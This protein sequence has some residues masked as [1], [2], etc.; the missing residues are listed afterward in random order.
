MTIPVQL[1]N[2]TIEVDLFHYI[3]RHTFWR[4]RDVLFFWGQIIAL[5]E[6]L[7][8]QG[9]E[10][11]ADSVKSQVA[12]LGFYIIETEFISEF[13]DYVGNLEVIVKLFEGKHQAISFDEFRS[14]L[15][16]YEP[17]LA[18]QPVLLDNDGRSQ[19][20][21]TLSWIEI[22]YRIGFIGFYLQPNCPLKAR[23]ETPWI[24]IHNEGDV[25]LKMIKTAHEDRILI[26]IHP[27][28]V[29]YLALNAYKE[30]LVCEMSDEYLI[31]Q[32]GRQMSHKV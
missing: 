3:L 28:F 18:F 17:Q 5:Y 26:T 6:H 4:P 8:E 32:E 14:I 1:N 13:K 11:N 27:I 15:K 20:R 31:R 24:Y 19:H 30:Q 25:I 12:R 22:L 21:T 2:R 9:F 7:Q 23:F 16:G 29:E 10:M